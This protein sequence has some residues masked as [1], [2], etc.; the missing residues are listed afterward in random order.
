MGK[1]LMFLA[2]CMAGLTGCDKPESTSQTADCRVQ[3]CPRARP[4]TP[5]VPL[6]RPKPRPVFTAAQLQQYVNVQPHI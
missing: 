2:L 5:V 1:A 4:A 3:V 6:I